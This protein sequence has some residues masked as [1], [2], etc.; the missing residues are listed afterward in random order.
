MRNTIKNSWEDLFRWHKPKLKRALDQ[1]LALSIP[2][3]R[4]AM[5]GFIEIMKED[6]DGKKKDGFYVDLTD[7]FESVSP[8]SISQDESKESIE[9]AKLLVQLSKGA[10]TLTWTDCVFKP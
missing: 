9:S 4:S 7:K 8:S 3:I 5:L 10:G 2:Q 6:L 1:M